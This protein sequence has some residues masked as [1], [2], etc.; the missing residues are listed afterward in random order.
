MCESWI[1]CVRRMRVLDREM[2]SAVDG[3]GASWCRLWRFCLDVVQ[4]V[5]DIELVVA[6]EGRR[7][8]F[9]VR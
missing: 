8:L 1:R 2:V 4:L 7:R 6:V 3:L 9:L 5:I